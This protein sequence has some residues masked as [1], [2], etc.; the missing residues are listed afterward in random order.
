M[1][2]SER[3]RASI[4][5]TYHALGIHY[6]S[7]LFR[8]YVVHSSGWSYPHIYESNMRMNSSHSPYHSCATG[9][10]CHACRGTTLRTFMK[11]PIYLYV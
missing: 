1:W 11:S 5:V 2:H 3:Y 9:Q 7:I 8:A 10:V 6:T 4:Y